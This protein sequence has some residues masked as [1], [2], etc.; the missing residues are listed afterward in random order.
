MDSAGHVLFYC[1]SSSYSLLQH[2]W[3]QLM[4]PASFLGPRSTAGDASRDEIG[5]KMTALHTALDPYELVP[6]LP[7]GDKNELFIV[8]AWYQVHVFLFFFFGSHHIATYGPKN[9]VILSCWSS[10]SLASAVRLGEDALHSAGL[11]RIRWFRASDDNSKRGGGWWKSRCP[12]FLIGEW[13]SPCVG[14]QRERREPRIDS[15]PGLIETGHVGRTS[16][17]QS[18]S[19]RACP[20]SPY[21]TFIDPG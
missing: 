21:S 9:V 19:L 13:L 5:E 11:A 1:T 20:M 17:A 16:S 4:M 2:T 3:Q 18:K 14:G 8:L 15:M 10:S 12:V 7:S 6:H